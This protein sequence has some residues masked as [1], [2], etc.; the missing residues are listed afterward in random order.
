MPIVFIFNEIGAA[1]FGGSVAAAAIAGLLSS[2]MGLS[3][4]TSIGLAFVL[5][6][7]ISIGTDLYFRLRREEGIARRL[8]HHRSGGHIFF[9]PVWLRGFIPVY[10]LATG[11]HRALAW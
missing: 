11:A 8:F 10:Y 5:V 3:M 2:A 9:I 1:I 4:A 6:A 7:V